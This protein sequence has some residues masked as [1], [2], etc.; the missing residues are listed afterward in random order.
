MLS[1]CCHDR[2]RRYGDF[3]VIDVGS[4]MLLSETNES[5]QVGGV[6]ET[7]EMGGKFE[8]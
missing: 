1:Y 5:V 8:A 3:A 4:S 7:Q 2:F 6:G